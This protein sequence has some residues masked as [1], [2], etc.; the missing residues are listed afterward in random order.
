MKKIFKVIG[1]I[2]S[3]AVISGGLYISSQHDA[4]LQK[5]VPMIE[6]KASE[7]VGTQIKIGDVEIEK[8]NLSKLQPSEIILHDIEIFDKNSEH[9]AKVDETKIKLKIF[10]LTD[11]PAGAVDE[12]NVKSADVNLKKRDDGTWNFDDIKMESTGESNFGAKIFVEDSK[13]NA[14]F[15]GKNIL[16]EEISGSADCGNL[17]SVDTK[18]SAKIFDSK[19]DAWGILGSENQIVHLS[20]DKVDAEKFVQYIPENTL[21]DSLEIIDGDISDLKLHLN[22]TAGNFKLLGSA[23]IAD[24]SVKV[25]NTEI[26]NIDGSTTFSNSEISFNASAQANKQAANVSGVVRLDTDETFFDIHA[27]SES[28]APSAIIENI[29]IEGAAKVK[30]HLIGTAKNPQV[31]AEIFSD[32]LAYENLSARNL[33]TNLRY[34]NN[35]VVLENL[36]GETFG[37]YVEGN[38][39]ISTDD[40][41]Y[42]AHVKSFGLNISDLK[43]FA[44]LDAQAY[45]KLSGDF[46]VDGVGKDLQK[47]KIFGSAQASNVNYEGFG[48]NN[49]VTSFYLNGNNLKID[50]CKAELPSHGAVGIEGTLTDGNKMDFNF[51]GAHIDMAFAKVFDSSFDMSGISDFTG[52]IHGDINNPQL[53]IKFSAV[54]NAPRGG[55][56]FKGTFFKQPFDSLKFSASGNLDGVNIDNFEI[57]KGGR[58]TWTVQKGVIGFTGEKKIDVELLTNR[59][60]VEDLVALVAPDQKF[61]GNLN[62]KVKITGTLNSPRVAGQIDFK[63]GSY[64]GILVSGIKGEYFVDD[65]KIRVQELNI[66]SPMVDMVLNGTIDRKTKEIDFVAQGSDISLKRLQVL[67][68]KT[69]PVEGHGKFEGLIT[70][71]VDNPIFNGNLDAENL[72]FNGVEISNVHGHVG[73]NG[74]NIVVDDFKFNQDEGFCN[75]YLAGNTSTKMMS[76]NL[77]AE[78]IGIEELFKLAGQEAKYLSGRLN[79]KISVSGT[80]DKPMANLSGNIIDGGIVGYD[81]HD[82]NFEL[83]YLNDIIYFNKF[84]GKQGDIGE[85]NLLGTVGFNSPI[86]LNLTSKNLELGIF[87]KLAGLDMEVTGHTDINAKIDGTVLNPSA[88]INLFASGSA[89]GATFDSIKSHVIFKDWVCDVKNF[90]V[91]RLIGTQ[92][93]SANAKGRLPIQAFYIDP[94]ENITKDDEF[95]LTVSLDGADLSLLPVLSKYV[96]WA[97]GETFGELKITGT[98]KNPKINGAIGVNDGTVKFKGVNSMVEGINIAALFKGDRFDIENFTGNIGNGT[99]NLE[100]GFNFANLRLSD[101]NFNL[102]AEELEII[103]GFFTGPVNAEFSLTEGQTKT[104]NI[105]PKISG[106]LNLDRCVIGIPSIPES[107]EPLPEMILDVSLELGKRVHLYSSRLFDMFLTGSAHFGG[108]TTFPRPSGV[109]SV[110]RGGTVTYLQNIFDVKVGE[111]HFDQYGSFLPNLNFHAETRLTNT[112]IFLDVEGPLDKMDLKLRSNP[113]MSESEIMQ[114]LTFRDAYDKGGSI[115]FGLADALSLGLQMSVIGEIEDTIK[116]N[117]G[118]DRFILTSGSGSAFDRHT[119]EEDSHGNEFNLSIGKYV[120]DKLMIRYTQ[121]INGQKISRYGFQYDINDNMGIT[122]EHESGEFIFGFEAR[123]NF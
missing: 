101:Y 30:A 74:D 7:T 26:K 60:R 16:L 102:K 103:S 51:Y 68:P 25:E 116:R 12:I 4:L 111:A 106:E 1:G 83:N 44:E 93:V 24:G 84:E 105:L 98:A 63:Y 77:D 13:L 65:D 59:A 91:L 99:L 90:T 39:E 72:I 94:G 104:G 108:T 95:D 107:D 81:L 80:T 40:L 27:D 48:I 29:G 69:Y 42:T 22:R 15:D 58:V 28:F 118:L 35:T 86:D 115:S 113:E 20:A 41:S 54:D 64:R 33:K 10:S 110:R 61:T 37:G 85:F 117:L 47:L 73:I 34:G 79:T 71:T 89:G 75:L 5:F 82:V 6:E 53:A 18:V 49:A 8:L 96:S 50:N 66:T 19:I 67:F 119:R 55:E 45:G 23:E 92:S 56:H 57:E 120:T 76:G 17:E 88:D 52:E 97:V 3:A 31:D 62:N 11:D 114:V 109:I 38:A 123:Y 9:I 2:L 121:G 21:P 112:K 36:S 14:D 78:N 122:V 70:G 87:S 32:Y 43:N 46:V 100:G